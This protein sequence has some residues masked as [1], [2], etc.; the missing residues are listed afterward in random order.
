MGTY[1]GIRFPD[2]VAPLVRHMPAVND[3]RE[4]LAALS[5]TWDTLA[6]L[7]QLSDLR[8]DMSEVR[9]GFG[10]LT[11]DL[12]AC[13]AEE[14]LALAEGTLGRRAQ[15]ALDLL[16]RTLFERNADIGVMAADPVLVDCC[17]AIFERLATRDE[18]LAFV[19][20]QG[21]VVISNDAA[22]RP[23]GRHIGLRPGTATLRLGGVTH[24]AAQR[25]GGPDQGYAGPGWFAL[26]L[27]P[28][29]VAFGED[30]PGA[31]AVAFSGEDVF[32]QRVLDVPVRA[33]EI[34]RR[35]DRMVWN[36]RFRQGAEPNAFSRSLLQEIAATGRK[37][38]DQIE[39]AS[40]ELLAT[41]A[42]G[43]LREARL[44]A[45]L[46]VDMLE[47][48]LRKPVLVGDGGPPFEALL[49]SALPAKPGAVAA[50]CRGD[51]A[52]IG[53]TGELPVTLPTSVLSL[54]PGQ[55]WSGVLVEG[56]L[57][58]VVGATVGSGDREFEN[59]GGHE[60][61]VIGVIVIPCGHAIA[62]P[63]AG[64][65]QIANVPGGTEVATFLIG[66]H[67]LGVPARDVVE[68]IAVTAAVRVW[69]GGFAQRHVGFVTWNDMAL[70][71]VDIAAD[72]S[73]AG[74][75]QCHALVLEAG[76]QRF[77][78]LVSELGPVAD[79]KLTEE[80]GLTGHGDATRLIAQLARSGPVFIPVLSPEAIFGGPA[81]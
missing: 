5:G 62:R 18:V 3:H 65:P 15:I 13:L 14:L 21:R 68:C 51:G 59:G 60:D 12:L 44:L 33:A 55:S 1:K 26:A 74:A 61:V 73:A 19:D 79:M 48:G 22:R 58:F 38:K 35:L 7:A 66:D 52:V 28:V 69:R 64:P 57:S 27:A 77:G 24:L 6:L 81:G 25:Q 11:A 56:G 23:A 76:A 42:A 10:E 8:A 75:A 47:R 16:A 54:A 41:A 50:C 70:P 40:S 9:A 17:A 72:I 43:L 29:E 31:A 67:L 78:L 45:G 80:R 49:Q 34:Q 71:L 39:R 53:R 63:A 4:A 2:H 36:S 20:A 30:P 37:T 32:P 46:A